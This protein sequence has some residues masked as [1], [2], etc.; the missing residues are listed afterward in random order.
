MVCY[1][2]ENVDG[3]CLVGGVRRL[4]GH[5]V[6]VSREGKVGPQ[7]QHRVIRVV[8]SLPPA[9]KDQFIFPL[10]DLLTFGEHFKMI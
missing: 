1:L 9:N 4:H 2:V 3:L 7:R 8:Q 10:I 6:G 5:Q